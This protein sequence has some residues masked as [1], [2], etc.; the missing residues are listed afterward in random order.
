MTVFP[1]SIAN[2]DVS[3]EE[4]TMDNPVFNFF[5]LSVGSTWD[6][7]FGDGGTSVVHSLEHEYKKP[8][9]YLITLRTCSGNFWHHGEW[10]CSQSFT[11]PLPWMTW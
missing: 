11:F 8:G 6:W 4:L 5:N 10:K 2:F 3:D 7:N 1:Q 9:Q